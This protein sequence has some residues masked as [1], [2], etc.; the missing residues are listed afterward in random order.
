LICSIRCANFVYLHAGFAVP[1]CYTYR[2]AS[3]PFAN[4]GEDFAES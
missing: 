3:T 2:C 4:P 1:L